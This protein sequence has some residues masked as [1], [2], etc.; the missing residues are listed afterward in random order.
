[1]NKLLQPRD[2]TTILVEKDT[3][4]NLKHMARKDQTYD[5]LIKELTNL[6]EIQE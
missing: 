3:L 5:Q 2:L 4:K 1:M 6:K